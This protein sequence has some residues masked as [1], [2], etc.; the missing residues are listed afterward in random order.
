MIG[1]D[2]SYLTSKRSFAA[3]VFPERMPSESP[4]ILIVLSIKAPPH[5][6]AFAL[7]LASPAG[8]WEDL[9]IDKYCRMSLLSPVAL[10]IEAIEAL[11]IRFICMP[12]YQRTIMTTKI[13]TMKA[14]LDCLALIKVARAAGWLGAQHAE[15]L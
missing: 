13:A 5:S 1:L 8:M 14:I 9:G 12:A 4:S 6:K 10:A 3:N 11:D 2:Q 7:I 15:N